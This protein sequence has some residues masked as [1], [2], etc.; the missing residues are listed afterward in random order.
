[1][2]L[3]NPLARGSSIQAFIPTVVILPFPDG[4]IDG[5]DRQAIAY[6][7]S[8]ITAG[9]PGAGGIGEIV[10][11]VVRHSPLVDLSVRAT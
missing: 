5:A 2:A 10:G 6:A 7:Y 4:N 9:V 3:D 8:G 1:M 11:F